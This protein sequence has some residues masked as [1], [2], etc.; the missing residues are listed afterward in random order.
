MQHRIEK[1]GP[2]LD[3]SGR[4]AEPGYATEPLLAYRR[5]AVRA[6]PIRL[7]E[8]DYYLVLTDT[9]AVALT[10]ADN[11]YMGLDSVSLLD[12]TVPFEK[13]VSRMRVFP[14]GRT[15]LPAS[16]KVGDVAVRGKGYGLSFS[17]EGAERVLRFHMDAFDGGEAIDGEIRLADEPP[18][19]MVIA[20]PFPGRPKAFY[21]NQKINCLRAKGTVRLGQQVYRFDPS[22][23]FGTLDWGRGVWTYRNTW[24]WSSCSALVGGVPFGFNLGY[25]FGDTSAASEN[26]LFYDG[27]AHKLSRVRFDIPQ[28]DGRD[29]LMRPWEISDDEGRLALCFMPVIDRAAKM[30]VGLIASNQH[31]VFGR[32]TGRAVLDDGRAIE[33]ESLMGFAEKVANRW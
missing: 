5:D 13:T 11:G 33:L 32:F 7:K 2:L 6:H 20:T 9:H 23:A 16:S 24:Y 29:D 26:M 12:F 28:S 30:S 21:Y 19:S 15:G 22:C 3:E 8:W 14:M 4:L 10:I 31:Q 27:K 18:D 1:P 25:G 17:K